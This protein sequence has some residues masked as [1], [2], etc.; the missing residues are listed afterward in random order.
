MQMEVVDL[1]GPDR[2][3]LT[4]TPAFVQRFE[5]EYRWMIREEAKAPDRRNPLAAVRVYAVAT[6]LADL[7]RASGVQGLPD[8]APGSVLVAL[9]DLLGLSDGQPYPDREE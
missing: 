2:P 8:E 7:L 5:H 6:V 1:S 9:R 4:V 3:S